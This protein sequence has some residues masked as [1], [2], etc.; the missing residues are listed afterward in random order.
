MRRRNVVVLA[1]LA[2]VVLAGLAGALVLCPFVEDPDVCDRLPM[3]STLRLQYE[4]HCDY[5]C[6]SRF[7]D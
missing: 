4:T 7:A 6:R 2:G 1:L 3:C 5:E